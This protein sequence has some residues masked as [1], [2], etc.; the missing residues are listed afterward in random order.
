M[1]ATVITRHEDC[2]RHM[3][4]YAFGADARRLVPGMPSFRIL[5]LVAGQTEIVALRAQLPA[6]D[7]VTGQAVDAF[8]VHP[9]LDERTPFIAF[10]THMPVG[11]VALR[12][13]EFRLEV[14]QQRIAR[15][16]IFGK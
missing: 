1:V 7:V 11:P 2:F 12:V 8:L 4:A 10:A 15:T 9:A 5:R 14:I 13:H 3:T 6:M 16:K